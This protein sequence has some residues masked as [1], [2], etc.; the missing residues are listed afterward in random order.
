MTPIWISPYGTPFNG[1]PRRRNRR[2]AVP[3]VSRKGG[4]VLGQVPL[5]VAVGCGRW[6]ER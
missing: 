3:D 5:S 2:E 1:S 4:Q 6:D